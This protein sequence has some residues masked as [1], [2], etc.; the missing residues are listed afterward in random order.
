MF[1]QPRHWPLKQWCNCVL[2]LSHSSSKRGQL[3]SFKVTQLH[4]AKHV[5][6]N[7][8]GGM[9]CLHSGA[10]THSP[11]FAQEHM[12]EKAWHTG[13]Y[14][15]D[16]ASSFSLTFYFLSLFFSFIHLHARPGLLLNVHCFCCHTQKRTAR[17]GILSTSMHWRR[18]TAAEWLTAAQIELPSFWRTF[19]SQFLF[20]CVSL[21][22]IHTFC[23][24][25]VQH[26]TVPEPTELP[27]KTNFQGVTESCSKPNLWKI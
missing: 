27:S 22:S 3:S 14:I 20:V 19:S 1:A 17:T 23:V 13:T 7:L 5:F 6:S 15:R 9:I 26:I 11:Q 10:H 4:I 18:G 8:P 24:S 12:E 16:M 21:T 2:S 25:Y